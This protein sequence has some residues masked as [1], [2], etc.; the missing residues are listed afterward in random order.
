[1]CLLHHLHVFLPP[2]V[3]QELDKDLSWVYVFFLCWY[4]NFPQ[5]DAMLRLRTD[6]KQGVAIEMAMNLQFPIF[7][8]F[9]LLFAKIH[10]NMP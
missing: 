2:L 5:A 1:M 6:E 3:A 9:R 7:L 10:H 4:R 8:R